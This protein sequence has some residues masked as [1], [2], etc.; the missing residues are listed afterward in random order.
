MWHCWSSPAES[1]LVGITLYS[2][3]GTGLG[4]PKVSQ[5]HHLSTLVMGYGL[6][7]QKTKMYRMKQVGEQQKNGRMK[8][9]DG[10]DSEFLASKRP[11]AG[12]K[13]V[14]LY[15]LQQCGW[16]ISQIQEP[17]AGQLHPRW[18]GDT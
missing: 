17:K 1:T 3:L 12:L 14:E 11:L 4:C 13:L 5:G 9:G 8:E 16:N 2:A 10:A 18:S 15:L 7:T 6:T